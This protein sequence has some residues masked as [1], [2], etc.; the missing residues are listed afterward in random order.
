MVR[1]GAQPPNIILNTPVDPWRSCGIANVGIEGVKPTD[2]AK[3]LHK[4]YRIWTVG[5]DGA[6][7][8]GCRITPN[9]YSTPTELDAFVN[10]LK[11]IAEA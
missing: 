1:P 9:I 4:K 3:I 8:H 5:I 10:A 2:L 6:G 7:V 11:E